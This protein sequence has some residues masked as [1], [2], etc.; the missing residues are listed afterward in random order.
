MN[1]RTNMI[2]FPA[3]DLTAL[4]RVAGGGKSSPGTWEPTVTRERERER[5]R[6]A[7][8]LPSLS[9]LGPIDERVL[10][11]KELVRT[12]RWRPQPQPVDTGPS[13]SGGSSDSIGSAE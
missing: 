11:E 3:I 12:R 5:P 7:V 2:A 8:P 9:N 4:A 1:Q 10:R 13:G 6:P